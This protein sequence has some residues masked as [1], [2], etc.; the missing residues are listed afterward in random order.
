MRARSVAGATV[1]VL[2]G[3]LI[4]AGAGVG[5]A[6]AHVTVNPREATQGGFTKLAFRVPN[7]SDTASTTKLEIVIPTDAPIAF[8]SIRPV[9]GWTAALETTKLAT[10]V[11]T[12]D[13][14]ITEA[15]SKITW[16]S[17]G[18]DSAIKTGQ[19]QEFEV[20]AGPLPEVDQ[21]IFKALQ[22]YSDGTIVRWIDNPPAASGEEPEHP[23][24][25]LKLAKAPA[26]G[27]TGTA[28]PAA[29]AANANADPA[30]TSGRDTR[31]GWALGLGVAGLAAGMAGLA[32]GLLGWRRAANRG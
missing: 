28:G 7:E 17:T 15:V 16:T 3:V 11:K 23:A 8:I 13:G 14:E 5:P 29:A 21:I 9:L 31:S 20:S 6:S 10:P 12:H 19:F 24:P 27:A 25:V 26:A 18:A 32:F 2:A 4:G 30:A 22:T 1:A